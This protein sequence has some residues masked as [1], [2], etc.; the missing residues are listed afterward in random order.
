MGKLLGKQQLERPRIRYDN[1]ETVLR[2]IHSAD[3]R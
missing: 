3:E 2:E 1:I